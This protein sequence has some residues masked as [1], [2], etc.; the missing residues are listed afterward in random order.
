MYN[1]LLWFCTNKPPKFGGDDG[2][3]VYDRIMLME[4]P[5][6]IPGEQQDKMLL[7]RLCTESEGITAVGV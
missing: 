4:C 2:K 6:I 5:N 7:D 3:W 1:G